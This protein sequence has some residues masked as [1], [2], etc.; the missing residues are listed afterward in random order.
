MLETLEGRIVSCVLVT[1][2][3]AT[4]RYALTKESTGSHLMEDVVTNDGRR[5]DYAWADRLED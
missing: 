5:A 4:G 2:E 3:L 1:G